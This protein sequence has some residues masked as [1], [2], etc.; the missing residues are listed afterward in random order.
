MS[1][2]SSD[3]DNGPTRH[4]RLLAFGLELAKAS[5]TRYPELDRSGRRELLAVWTEFCQNLRAL[6][7]TVPAA[8]VRLEG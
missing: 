3:T 1:T 2:L 8:D 4:E 5:V 7:V 6:G